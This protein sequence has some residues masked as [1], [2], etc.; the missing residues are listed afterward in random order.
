MRSGP[1]KFGVMCFQPICAKDEVVCTNG[2][3]VEFGA[4]LVEVIAVVLD[5]DSLDGS[6]A[7]GASAVHGSVDIFYGQ[8]QAEGA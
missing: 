4:F 5:A 7:Y 8:G 6:G 3:D 2:G 1:V